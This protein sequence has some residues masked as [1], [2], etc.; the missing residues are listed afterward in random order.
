MP[1]HDFG[2]WIAYQK[3]YGPVS[4]QERID[5]G[6]AKLAFYVVAMQSRKPDRVRPNDFLPPYL[7]R[8]LLEG[9]GIRTPEQL[10]NA[11]DALVGMQD[12]DH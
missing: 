10:K 6:F 7:R 11:L 9:S 2:Q 4:I 1:V 3:V 8:L 12:A 5:L